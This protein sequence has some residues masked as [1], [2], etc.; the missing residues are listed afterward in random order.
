[1]EESAAVDGDGHLEPIVQ[2]GDDGRE[3]AAPTDAGDADPIGVDLLARGEQRMAANHGG[4]GVVGPHGVG[5]LGRE[6]GELGVVVLRRPAVGKTLA[7]GT[8]AG[9]VHGQRRVPALGPERGPFGERLAAAAVDEDHGR[10][11]PVALGPGVVGEHPCRF[12][13]QRLA[14]VVDLFEEPRFRAPGGR[15]RFLEC[16]EVP[17][18][19]VARRRVGG[20][21]GT[22]QEGDEQ[23]Q[24]NEKLRRERIQE[25]FH[26]RSPDGCSKWFRGVFARCSISCTERGINGRVHFFMKGDRRWAS[27]RPSRPDG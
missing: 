15:G 3:I 21:R 7:V 11:G 1:M 19:G 26:R 18:A 27:C 9:Q 24:E 17:G 8:A 2:P 22:E 6:V 16:F 25:T 4:H 12:A 5:G 23:Q 13:R 20:S 14:L 10:Q